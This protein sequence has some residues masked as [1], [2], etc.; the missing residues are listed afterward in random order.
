MT[1]G[2]RRG[3]CWTSADRW[4]DSSWWCRPGRRGRRRSRWR[5]HGGGCRASRRA[6]DRRHAVQRG[7]GGWRRGRGRGCRCRG[8]HP[9]RW[10]G[11]NLPATRPLYRRGLERWRRAWRGRPCGCRAERTQL[12]P[13]RCDPEHGTTNGTAGANALRG[14]LGG[15]DP[16][17]RIAA[18]TRYVHRSHLNGRRPVHRLVLRLPVVGRPRRST[19]AGSWR[20]SSFRLPAR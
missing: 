16:K 13:I 7:R 15:I 11:G 17:D 9:L 18:G 6:G 14:N 5:R 10:S 19:Q 8:C 12:F 4:C 20:S 2:G 3:C 1:G